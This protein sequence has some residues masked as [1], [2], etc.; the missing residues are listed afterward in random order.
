[1]ITAYIGIGS[2]IEREKHVEAALNELDHLGEQLRIS[3]IYECDAVGF[4][5]EPFYNLV[6]ELRTSLSLMEFSR[7]LRDIELK[8][9][10]KL[11]AG[12][13][14]PRTVDLDLILFGDQVSEQSPQVPRCDIYKY[15]FVIQPLSE[16]CPNLV[17]PEDG[18]TIEQIFK[19]GS[20][21]QP[22]T[23]VEPWFTFSR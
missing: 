12:K 18:R 16:L 4:D 19:A 17:V 5:S 22:L 6:A 15:R 13:Y 11:D 20:D 9:G 21:S 23:A 14:E 2:N 1:M 3:T 7:A 10:R 8:W